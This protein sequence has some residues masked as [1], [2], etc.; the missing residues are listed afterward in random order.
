M[1]STN[2][3]PNDR[4]PI[5]LPSSADVPA[6]ARERYDLEPEPDPQPTVTDV[7]EGVAT[8]L[9]AAVEL[10]EPMQTSARCLTILTRVQAAADGHMTADELLRSLERLTRG[11]HS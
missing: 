4:A 6:P 10:A 3:S 1:D 7:L 2:P 8:A 9:Q 5:P 11:W